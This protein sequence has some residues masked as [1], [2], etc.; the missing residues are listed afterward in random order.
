M[1]IR[2]AQDVENLGLYKSFLNF[3]RLFLPL[4]MQA[5]LHHHGWLLNT[6]TLKL[7]CVG[8]VSF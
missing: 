6:K 3:R 2:K 1:E 4:M 8:A 5:A 7:W